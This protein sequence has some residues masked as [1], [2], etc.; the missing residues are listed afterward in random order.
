MLVVGC[1]FFSLSLFADEI[2]DISVTPNAIYTG[3]TFHGYAEMRIVL[4]NDSPKPHVVTL[5]YPNNP[6]G[7]YGNC[8]GR[9]SR[10]VTLA[11]AATEVVSLLQPPLP[12]RGDGSIGVEV[13]GRHEGE[14]RAPNSGNHCNYY[15]RGG[16]MATVFISRSLDYDAVAHVFQ[17]ISGGAY[18]ATRAT[19]APDAGR[20][21]GWDPNAWMPD[22]RSFGHTNWLEL[23]YAAPQIVDRISVHTTQ[24]L[25]AIGS[26]TLVGISGTN[27]LKIP[28]SSGINSMSGAAPVTTFTGARRFAPH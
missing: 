25:S 7:N 9:L 18:T 8:I 23:D 10:T 28:M 27:L 16:Q 3:N 1:F 22:T 5:V 12:A 14:V 20:P 13:D 21:G 6:Y 26:V 17:A 11:P 4:S 19:G 2:A 24:P 15:T